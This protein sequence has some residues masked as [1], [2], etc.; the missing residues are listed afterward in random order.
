MTGVE[1][2]SQAERSIDPGVRP[3]ARGPAT[4]WSDSTERSP[5]A[6]FRVYVEDVV[7]A[8]DARG[9]GIGRLLVERLLQLAPPEAVTSLLCFPSLIDFY[10]ANAFRPTQQVVMHRQPR[11]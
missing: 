11:D 4:A 6:L 10:A 8:P 7:V 3:S 2:M 5:T 1:V 9:A